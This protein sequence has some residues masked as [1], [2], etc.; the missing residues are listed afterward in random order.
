[1]LLEEGHCLREHALD[2]C[3]GKGLKCN[4]AVQ[5]T[6]LYTMIE[7][8]AGGRGIT[9]IPEMAVDST[10]V[11]QS[12]IRLTSIQMQ[13]GSDYKTEQSQQKRT[14]HGRGGW[15]RP[16]RKQRGVQIHHESS[17]STRVSRQG[18]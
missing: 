12:D 6:G 14:G 13:T 18:L 15:R 3:H 17:H 9:F 1:M 7:M 8:V 5:G 4:T 2:A 16:R 10:L 11:K